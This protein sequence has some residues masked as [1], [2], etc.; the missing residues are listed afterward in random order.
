MKKI[1]GLTVREILEDTYSILRKRHNPQEII[2]QHKVLAKIAD[3]SDYHR[4][5]IGYMGY[6]TVNL[7]NL[8]SKTWAIAR[9]EKCGGYPADPYDSDILALELIVKEQTSEQIQEELTGR[10]RE[11]LFFENSLVYGTANGNLGL[12]KDGKFGKRMLEILRPEID[13]FIAQEPEYDQRHLSL[14]TLSPICKKPVLYK[15]ELAGFLADSIE[16]ILRKS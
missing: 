10:I 12:N 9:G 8:N 13:R 1:K 4:T 6:K 3:D 5:R 14:S 2:F 16:A 7:L 11:S 15:P